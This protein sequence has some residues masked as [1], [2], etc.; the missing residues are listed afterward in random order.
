MNTVEADAPAVPV[1]TPRLALAALCVAAF[2]AAMNFFATSP[3]YADIADDLDTSVPLLGQLVTVMLLVSAA[4]GL[5]VGPLADRYGIR[6]LLILGMGAITLNLLGTS[7]APSYQWLIPL[8][9]LGALGDALVFGLAFA[10]ASTLFAAESRRRAIGWTMASISVGPVVGVP[11]LT[12]IGGASGWRVAVGLA[13]LVAVAGTWMTVAALPVDR[14]RPDSRL[15]LRDLLASYAPI[16][17]H[18]PTMRLLAVAGLR[19]VWMLG[20]VTYIGAYLRDDLGLSTER[21][22]LYYLVAGIG[23]TLG[24]L[25]GGSRFAAIR[26]RPTIAALNLIGGAL[27]ATVLVSSASMALALLPLAATIG[28]MAS[29]G[30]TALLAVESPAE[31]GTTMVLNTSLLNLGAAVGAAVGGV[32]IAVGGYG[33]MAVGLPVFALAAAILTIRSDGDA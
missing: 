24:S 13:G 27:V 10:L 33:A 17:S 23:T 12:L 21:V 28:V 32:L 20:L 26:P 18:P 15:R 19:A 25:A 14:R 6:E 2:F 3:F 5:V 7:V 29:V 8:A 22:G 1:A 16:R 31:P 30:I 9:I 11:L 4:L